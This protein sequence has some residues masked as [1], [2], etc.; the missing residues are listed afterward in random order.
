MYAKRPR[1]YY[2][3]PTRRQ[4]CKPLIRGSR[5]A[6]ARQCLKH[7]GIRRYMI[8]RIGLSLQQEIANLCSDKVDSVLQDKCINTLETFSWDAVIEEMTTR[9]PTLLSLLENCTHTKRARNNRKSVIGII[10]AILCK[11]RRPTASLLQRLLS[12][13]WY[14]GHAA[15]SVRNNTNVTLQIII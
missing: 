10:T 15:K 9:A 12:I 5:C 13:V 1:S 2:L 8:K 7:N 11:H 14:A 3:T 4:I 6:L